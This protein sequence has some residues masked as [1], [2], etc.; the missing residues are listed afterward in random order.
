M[1]QILAGAKGEGKTKKLLEMANEAGKT[2]DGHVV[3]I[4]D[5]KRHMYDLHYNIRFVETSSF[6][7]EDHAV[8]FGFICGI[9]SQDG[10]IEKIYIDGLNNIVKGMAG[11][12]Y[13]AFVNNLEKLSKEEEVD[14][15]MIISGDKAGLPE[16]LA[17][18]FI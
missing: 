18:Y 3:F 14:F 1:V 10:D 6:P 9:L 12:D 4:D 15:I 8:L 2:S 13:V 7:M 11:D 17:P 16:G 5:D